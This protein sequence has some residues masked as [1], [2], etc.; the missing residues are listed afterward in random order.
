ME[1]QTLTMGNQGDTLL[2]NS[3]TGILLLTNTTDNH[4]QAT[5]KIHTTEI[6]TIEDLSHTLRVTRPNIPSLQLIIRVSS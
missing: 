3:T 2:L 4:L 5:T 6:L 1:D